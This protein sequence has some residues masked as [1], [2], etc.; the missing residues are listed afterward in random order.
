MKDWSCYL[1]QTYLAKWKSQQTFY[2]CARLSDPVAQLD[3]A[4]VF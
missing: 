2:F 3:R 4:T 1:N